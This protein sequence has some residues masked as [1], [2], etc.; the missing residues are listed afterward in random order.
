MID[1]RSRRSERLSRARLELEVKRAVRPA[2]VVGIGA[3]MGLACAIYIGVHVSKTL[4]A[5]TYEVRF[6]VDDATGVVAGK[7]DVRYKGIPAGTITKV[8]TA[9][10]QP[11][12]TVRVQEKYGRVY[13][14]ARAALRPNTALQDM[15]LDV[16]DRGTRAAGVAT[17]DDPVPAS[18]T[19]T[20]VNL[21][22]VLNVFRADERTRLRALLDNFGNGLRDRGA[23]LRTAFVQAVPFLDV[24]GRVSDQLA[25]RRPMTKRLV[26]NVA[27]LA[28]ELRRRDA[29]LRRLL[30]DGSTTL[31]TLKDGSGDL[32]AT[33]AQLPPTLTAIDSS[34]GAVRGVIGDV[35][36]AVAS[37][38]PVA[39]RLSASLAAVRRLNDSAAPAVRA[40]QTPIAELVPLARSLA[41]L[42]RSLGSAVAALRPQVDTVDLV[43]KRASGCKRGIQGFF[44]W[45]ASMSK[46]GDVRGPVPRGN[47]AMGAQSSGVLTSPDEHAPQACTPGQPIGGRVPAPEDKH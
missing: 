37:L 45:D 5:S 20:S 10:T 33:L 23:S 8:E 4:L 47:V 13:R 9:G 17:V 30:R 7:N 36:G 14:D 28:T 34:F 32:D 18:G 1:V 6:A 24:A 11:V 40:L 29:E 46:Y 12:L 44:Q 19:S 3:L 21:A 26:H 39:G 38:R 43:T 25:R 27:L 31:T 41:P 42:S 16:L 22:D 35:D 15:Y 2:I